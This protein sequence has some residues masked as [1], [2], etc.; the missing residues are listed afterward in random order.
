M[1]ITSVH[2]RLAAGDCDQ[3]AL[4]LRAGDALH[5]AIAGDNGATALI[6]QGG[7]IRDDAVIAAAD[8]GDRR[9]I[10]RDADVPALR[11]SVCRHGAVSGPR[12][13]SL[14]IARSPSPRARRRNPALIDLAPLYRNNLARGG[15]DITVA[16][17]AALGERRRS[18]SVKAVL[19]CRHWLSP[20]PPRRSGAQLL[21]GRFGGRAFFHN[22]NS[23]RKKG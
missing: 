23:G 17:Q 16:P 8:D 11:R 15:F 10:L 4:R 1:P 6:Q 22:Q 12:A 7:A 18:R 21:T 5:I 2:F 3:H 9:G 20:K 14:A 19:P 13:S